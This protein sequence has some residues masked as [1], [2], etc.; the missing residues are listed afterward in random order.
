M[1]D[2]AITPVS[3]RAYYLTMNHNAILKT[4]DSIIAS[5]L[6]RAI[7]GNPFLAADSEISDRKPIRPAT[8]EQVLKVMRFAQMTAANSDLFRKTIVKALDGHT[9][10][11]IDLSQTTSIDCAGLG[12]LIAVRKLTR[13]HKGVVRLVNPTSS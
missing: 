3:A 5:A 4:A 2:H 8:S 7:L 12:A 9:N 1:G 11:E 10:V 13:D 6:G